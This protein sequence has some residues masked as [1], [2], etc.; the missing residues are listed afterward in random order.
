MQWNI[1]SITCGPYVFLSVMKFVSAVPTLFQPID[2]RPPAF[3]SACLNS[4]CLEGGY[5]VELKTCSLLIIL[6]WK[7]QASWDTVAFGANMGLFP[8]LSRVRLW[9]LIVTVLMRTIYWMWLSDDENHF[10]NRLLGSKDI[11][12]WKASRSGRVGSG[13]SDRSGRSSWENYHIQ[14]KLS[15]IGTGRGKC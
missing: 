15:V 5:T 14:R 11:R 3:K 4:I 1:V 12:R 10:F 8:H 7:V 9:M 6:Q 13:R 2:V